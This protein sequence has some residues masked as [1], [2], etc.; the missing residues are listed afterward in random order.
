MIENEEIAREVSNLM[1]DF[2]HRLDASVARVQDHGTDEEFKTYRRAV[3]KVLGEMLLEIM[4]PL[5]ARHP[6][7]KP[8]GLK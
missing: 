3:G 7:L 2:S 4:N 1:I 8:D 5:Y 6:S